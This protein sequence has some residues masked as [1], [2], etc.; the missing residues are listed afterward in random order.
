M[1]IKIIR[2]P[3][4]I[5]RAE[6]PH[7]H[8]IL[9]YD[10]NCVTGGCIKCLCCEDYFSHRDYGKPH[11]MGE[12]EEAVWNKNMEMLKSGGFGSMNGEE[13]YKTLVRYWKAQ[14][15][16]GYPMASE[17]VKYFEDILRKENKYV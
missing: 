3:C 13:C 7:C 14:E 1:N 5:F 8:A 9:E 10:L 4:E 6:C 2:T 15:E 16:A 12:G 11:I 17:N